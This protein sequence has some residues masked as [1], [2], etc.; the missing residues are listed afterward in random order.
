MT[1]RS[2]KLEPSAK[3]EP[4]FRCDADAQ[5]RAGNAVRCSCFTK[6]YVYLAFG[7]ALFALIAPLCDEPEP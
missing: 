3:P 5:R 4:L 2:W 6:R 1:A 7:R